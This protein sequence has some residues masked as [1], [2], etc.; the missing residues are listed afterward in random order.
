LCS[1][2]VQLRIS[3]FEEPKSIP[4]KGCVYPAKLN[5]EWAMQIKER[6]FKQEDCI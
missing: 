6:T 4:D 3:S 1:D 2:A 5:E